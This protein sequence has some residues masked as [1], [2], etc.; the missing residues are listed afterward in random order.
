MDAAATETNDDTTT[1]EDV[2]SNG[3]RRW[4]A[5]DSCINYDH[6]KHNDDTPINYQMSGDLYILRSRCEYEMQNNPMVAGVVETHTIDLIG[7]CGPTLQVVSDSDRYNRLL[8][9]VFAE[10][11]ASCTVGGESGVDVLS[12]FN[13]NDWLRGN[14]L[15]Q[16]VNMSH[17]LPSSEIVRM[18]LLEIAP[19]RLK[20]PWGRGIY[21]RIFSGVEL[22]QLDRPIRYWIAP[23]Q[24][25]VEHYG[26]QSQPYSADEIHHWFD[27]RE[28]GQAVGF[29][30]LASCLNEIVELRSYDAEVLDAARTAA[31]N[32]FLMTTDM[33]EYI[34][35]ATAFPPGFELDSP[36]RTGKVLPP[37]YQAVQMTPRQPIANYADFRHEK[38]RSIG[39]PVHMP[40]LSILLSANGSNFSQSR[41]D[42]NVLYERG[43]NHIRGRM[44][45]NLL[46]PIVKAVEREASLATFF[47]SGSRRFVLGRKPKNGAKFFFRWEPLGHANPRDY[48]TSVEK[49][50]QLGLTSEIR[51][52]A[53]TG[54]KPEQIWEDRKAWK[55]MMEKAGFSPEPEEAEQQP[56]PQGQV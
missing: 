12:R 17:E 46:I 31:N 48:S 52:I 13:E 29:P 19:R 16:E 5:V 51:E 45:R 28:A 10:W 37:G 43:L 41:I 22:D 21:D 20:N 39:R 32:S 25:S 24:N 50:L 47:K 26:R 7:E 40:L 14:S 53:K 49:L 30:R 27:K 3:E 35:G 34:K 33:P 11:W 18:R 42:L 6:W 38:L 56:N 55:E 36:R 2:T 54:E 15:A 44:Q 8:E 4:E 9:E 1:R 23:S